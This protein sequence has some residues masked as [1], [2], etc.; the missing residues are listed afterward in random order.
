MARLETFDRE[1]R[2]ATAGIEPEA[3]NAELARFAKAELAKVIA[4]GQGSSVYTRYVNGRFGAAEESVKAP[5]PIL[6]EFAWWGPV[7]V[8]ALAELVKR[9]PKKSG[10]YASSFV[11]LA[12]GRPISSF[13]AILP[14][15]EVIIFNAQPYTRK[16]ETGGMVMTVP[17]RHF[18]G[19]ELAM[20]RLYGRAA[21]FAFRTAFLSLPGG[22][23]ALVP[24]VLKGRSRTIHARNVLSY[25]VRNGRKLRTAPRYRRDSRAGEKLT[26]PALIMNMVR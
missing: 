14:G 15:A 19:A 21:G 4:S 9:S 3:I 25:N 12:D 17:P 11:V 20:W 6:Y 24:Y 2:L 18:D 7:I 5:G 22:L 8:A 16:V 10:R 26:Y 1:I 13:E 23:H